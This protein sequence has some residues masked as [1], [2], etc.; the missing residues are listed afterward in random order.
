M[1][2]TL[3]KQTLVERDKIIIGLQCHFKVTTVK[4]RIT[5]SDHRTSFEL[6]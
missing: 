3:D 5:N 2:I 6:Y 4:L 1:G